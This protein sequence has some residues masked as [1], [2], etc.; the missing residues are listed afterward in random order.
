MWKNIF[1]SRNYIRNLRQEGECYVQYNVD[2]IKQHLKRKQSSERYEHTIGVAYTAICMAMR[3]DCDLKKAE[4]AGLLHDCAKCFSDEAQLSKC[5]KYHIRISEAER[6]APYLLHSKLGAF[7]AMDKFGITDKDMINAILYHTTGRPAMSTL[8]KIIYIADYI[9]PRRTKAQ[10]LTEIRR[11]A[12]VDLDITMLMILGD[13]L[14][15]LRKKQLENIDEMTV[16]AYD[17]YKQLDLERK[18]VLE[19]KGKAE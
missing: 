3:F 8:E 11:M 13:I 5:E 2:K 6:Q 7:I 9:E 10:N 12:F 18:E 1:I 4:I 15:Y 19:L 16:K 14:E 17:Y